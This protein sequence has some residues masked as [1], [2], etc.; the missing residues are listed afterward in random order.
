MLVIHY[1]CISSR[2]ASAFKKSSRD[3]D[4]PEIV[5]KIREN[6]GASLYWVVVASNWE[7]EEADT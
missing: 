3:L 7:S 2:T 1:I 5:K 4:V 6:E